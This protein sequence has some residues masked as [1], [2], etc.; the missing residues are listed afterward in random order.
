MFIFLLTGRKKTNG[1]IN[2][3]KRKGEKKGEWQGNRKWG[4]KE[5]K[6]EIRK[7]GKALFFRRY[8]VGLSQLPL[9]AG[10]QLGS[11]F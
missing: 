5:E 4:G 2:G 9:T 6:E 11:S 7:Y 8:C 10:F 3:R 1:K